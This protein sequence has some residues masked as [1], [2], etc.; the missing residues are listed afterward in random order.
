MNDFDREVV[1]AMGLVRVKLF[2]VFG[3]VIFSEDDIFD[4]QWSSFVQFWK[5]ARSNRNNTLFSKKII[6]KFAYLL[7][8]N[9]E[10]IIY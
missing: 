2:D 1:M 3:N 9:Y 10:F 8:F 7:S 6:K 5:L 4:G